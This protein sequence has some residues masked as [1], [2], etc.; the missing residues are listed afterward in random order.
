M[1]H[2][3]WASAEI[4]RRKRILSEFGQLIASGL[5]MAAAAKKLRQSFVTL[6]RWRKCLE[7]KTANC[8]RRTVLS[9]ANV[10]PKII[11]RVQR[12]QLAGMGNVAAW[13]AVGNEAGCPPALAEFL[14]AA[15]NIPPSFLRASRLQ[16]EQAIIIK[17]A[18]FTVTMTP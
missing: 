5:S 18:D 10:P 6:W 1:T 7:P 4:R 16:K 11:H 13:R 15:R 8:G 14:K 2:T 9:R 3:P 12:M 17:G